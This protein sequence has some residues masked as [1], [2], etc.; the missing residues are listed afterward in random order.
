MERH[1]QESQI[2]LLSTTC[3]ECKAPVLDELHDHLY[4]EFVRKEPEQLAGEATVPDSVIS[5]C[6]I[7]NTAKAFL[8]ASKQSSMFW[9]SKTANS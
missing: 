6:Q 3:G 8:F 5:C 1:F 9:I 4:H 2:A 7:T